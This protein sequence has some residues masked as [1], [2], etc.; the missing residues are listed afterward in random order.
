[1]TPARY[2]GEVAIS[3]V[4]CGGV[5]DAPAEVR[6]CWSRRQAGDQTGH[7]DRVLTDE[8]VTGGN[9]DLT[10]PRPQVTSSSSEPSP[11]TP[12]S[13]TATTSTATGTTSTGTSGQRQAPSPA[14]PRTASV[15]HPVD[16]PSAEQ[17]AGPDA[18]GRGLVISPGGDIPPPWSGAAVVHID[19]AVWAQPAA[20]VAELRDNAAHRRRVVIVCDVTLPGSVGSPGAQPPHAPHEIDDTP[21]WQLGPRAELLRDHLTHLMW[22]NAIDARDGATRWW[23]WDRAIELGASPLLDPSQGD[24]SVPDGIPV[25]LDGGPIGLLGDDGRIEDVAVVHRINLEH[26]SLTP[27]GTNDLPAH[28]AAMELAEDQRAAVTHNGGAA[29]IIAPAGSGKTR[30]LTERARHLVR[31]WQVPASAVSLVAFNRRAQSEM[32]DR[33]RDVRGL[34]V[35]TLNAIALAIV[36][37]SPPFAPRPLTL[38][39]IDEGEVRR[40]IA[41]LVSMPRRRNADPIAPWIEALGLVRLGLR[42]PQEVEAL[43]DGEVDGFAAVYPRYRDELARARCVDFDEQVHLALEVLLTDPTARHAAQ[44]A[45][46]LL[47]VD[48]FQDLTP[49]HLLLVRLLAGADGAVFGVGDDDQTIYGYNGADPAWLIDFAT[50]FPFAGEH[51]LHTNYRCPADVVDVVDRLLR[52]N[53][54]RVPKVI[55]SGRATGTGPTVPGGS[56]GWSAVS[57]ADPVGATADAVRQRITDGSAP[58]DV[59]VL[60]RVNSL[61][62]PVQVALGMHGIA[63]S[64]GVGSEFVDRTAVRSTLAWMRLGLGLWSSGDLT[65]AL[66]RPSRPLHPNVA[67]WV[68]E[69][70]DGDALGRLAERL[71]NERDA[72]RVR[73]FGA[74]IDRVRELVASGGTT[75]DVV[76]FVRDAIGLGNAVQTLDMNR[77]GMNRAAQNDDLTAL[78]QLAALHPE[79]PGFERWLRDALGA[80]RTDAGVAL[81]TVH[82]VK[83]QEWSHVVVHGADADQFPHRLADDEEEE[84]RLFHVALTRAIESATVVSG[85]DPSPFVAELTNEPTAPPKRTPSASPG[86]A[87]RKMDTATVRQAPARDRS[88]STL[89]PRAAHAFEKLRLMRRELADG[90]PAYTVFDDA[91][92]ERIALAQPSTLAELAALRGIGPTKLDLYGSAVLAVIADVLD[93]A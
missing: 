72:Q 61:L 2:K 92:L 49:A 90:K 8:Q 76:S 35:R 38:R 27:L 26:G 79:V 5:H 71:T 20:V 53:G 77:H 93:E 37:G 7:Q 30:V 84:R 59:A 3:C 74:D 12:V 69:Q 67:N 14:Q 10:P 57:V 25:W 29:R 83:G 78:G 43:Y 68:A 46:R 87:N 48:E 60:T 80:D 16:T 13:P 64:G 21:A 42:S 56:P 18:L 1:V 15:A 63:V 33:T 51:P 73:E 4:Y 58:A 40:I 47:L 88:R 45:N 89:S 70:H 36:N 31:Q 91:T 17:L 66:R 24:V 82:R 11:T 39:T 81:A 52:H 44:R 34:Q 9:N 62:A 86:R 23:L 54:R 19:D 65:E 32:A 22:S 75:V 50:L 28:G 41:S 85:P 6:A 55:R